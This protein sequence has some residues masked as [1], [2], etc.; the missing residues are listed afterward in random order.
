MLT[1]RQRY[2]LTFFLLV[3]LIPGAASLFR[4]EW[5]GDVA[6]ELREPQNFPGF[7][8]SVRDAYRWPKN[9]DQFAVDRFPFRSAWIGWLSAKLYGMGISASPEVILGK[10]DWLFLK[11]DTDELRKARGITRFSTDADLNRWIEGF[12]ARKNLLHSQ[13]VPMFFFAVPSKAS[14][15]PDKLPSWAQPVADSLTKQISDALDSRSIG[16]FYRLHPVLAEGAAHTQVF[17]RTDTHWNDEGCFLGYQEIMK[18]LPVGHVMKREDFVV[19]GE[20]KVRDLSRLLGLTENAE[21]SEVWA[22][23]HS[24]VASYP[25]QDVRE[26]YVLNPWKTRTSRSG[27]GKVLFFV[28]SFANNYLFKF[29]VESFNECMFVHYRKGFGDLALVRQ[30]KPDAV[31]FIVT[32]RLIPL[33]LPALNPKTSPK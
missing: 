2:L 12:N 17:Y 9:F 19:Q 23:A 15:Y 1:L 20:W 18:Q 7:P 29:L 6:L 33:E 5:G 16:G 13:G 31:V 4:P 27:Q 21:L 25:T 26:R 24:V 30:E 32:E 10:D 11:R 22:P 3:L 8:A 14:V 28:D